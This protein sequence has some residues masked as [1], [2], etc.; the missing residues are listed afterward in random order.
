LTKNDC[1]KKYQTE[2]CGGKTNFHI[3]DFVLKHLLALIFKY[4]Q[5]YLS[6][7]NISNR[8]NSPF[9]AYPVFF[10]ETNYS[11]EFKNFTPS[12]PDSKNNESAAAMAA[13][14][15]LFNVNIKII[16]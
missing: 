1:K 16:N 2:N 12:T 10:G 13:T 15:R 5:L 9:P 6:F 3:H 8:F 4:F 11:S 7:L 14:E